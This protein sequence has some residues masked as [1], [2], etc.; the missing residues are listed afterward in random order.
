MASDR[1]RS[2]RSLTLPV[3][4]MTCASCVLRVEKAIKKVEGVADAAVNLA[5]ENVRVEFDP[6]RVSV[7]QLQDAVAGSGYTLVT[8]KEAE[9]ADTDPGGESP[10][11]KKAFRLLRNELV[12]S[13]ALTVPIMV[14]SMLSMTEWYMRESPL[15]MDATN[16]IL[17]LLTTPVIFLSG[18]RFF[19]GFWV[20]ARHLTADMNTLVA[21]GT[22]A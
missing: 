3:E 12:L 16:K 14:L 20:T 6:T 5:G 22:G 11:K 19:R 2:V 4:G 13:A 1:D 8:P 21:V 18:R 7:G 17:L 10:E 9:S 15:S